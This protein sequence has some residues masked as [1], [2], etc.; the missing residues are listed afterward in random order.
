MDNIQTEPVNDETSVTAAEDQA[1]VIEDD[2]V[3]D[4]A[5]DAVSD[6]TDEI[7]DEV[8]PEKTE[9]SVKFDEQQQE[10]VN[11][12]ISKRVAKQREAE[13]R[14]AEAERQLQALQQQIPQPQIP[15]VPAAPNPDDYYGDQ[16]GF[17]NA[18]KERDE[19]ITK[20]AEFDAVAKYNEQAAYQSAMQAKQQ[21][22][23]EMQKR[24]SSYMEKAKT[25]GISNE[26]MVEDAQIVGGALP[27]E[28]GE[29]IVD[30]EQ[31]PLLASY[32]KN[33]VLELEQ[34]Q[35]MNPIAA[36]VYIERNVRPK[37]AGA[38]KQTNAPKPVT[39]EGGGKAPEMK[40]EFLKG[41]K[42]E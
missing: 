14:A 27:N 31:G 29:F 11:S 39:I 12:L 30:D 25:F 35:T 6:P 9:T 5:D 3:N 36:A 38:R 28:L 1:F 17:L 16:E 24:Q 15:E 8:E 40:S 37:L 20:R 4:V 18:L 23:A 2:E 33:N 7:T 32:F 21:R 13:Q 22:E 19:A 26:Q 42:F 10:K 34:V 41:A